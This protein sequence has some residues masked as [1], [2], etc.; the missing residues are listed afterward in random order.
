MGLTVQQFVRNLTETGIMSVDELG[1]LRQALPHENLDFT[2]NGQDAQSLAQELVRQHKLTEY[3]A[4]LLCGGEPGLTL[5][6]YIIMDDLGRGGMGRVFKAQH[7]R[8]KRVVALKVL[9]PTAMQ[10]PESV[11]RFQREVEAAAKLNHPNIVAAYD[12]DEEQG[13]H[14][15]VMEYV[16]GTSLG[17][18]VAGD[19]LDV[20]C[21]INYILQAAYALRY[22]HQQGVVHRDIKPTNLLL[23]AS[24]VVKVLDMGLARVDNRPGVLPEEPGQKLTQAGQIMGTIDFMSPEQ[25]EDTRQ[26]DARSDIYSLGCTMYSLLTGEVPYDGDT[27]MRKLLAHRNNPIPS[28]IAKRTDVPKELEAIFHRMVAKRPADR[29]QTM[30]EVIEA[31]ETCASSPTEG[32]ASGMLKHAFGSGSYPIVRRA[33]AETSALGADPTLASRPAAPRVAVPEEELILKEDADRLKAEQAARRPPPSNDLIKLACYCGHRFAVRSDHAGKKVKCPSCKETML[34]HRAEEKAPVPP[35]SAAPISVQCGQC[36]KRLTVS[37]KLAGK[38]VKCSQCS[39][40]IKIVAA[41][42]AERDEPASSAKRAKAT[43][44]QKI[45]ARC[46]CGKQLTASVNLAGKT[47]KCPSCSAPIKVPRSL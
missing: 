3:Q 45:S 30:S 16:E 24:G 6:S 10:S 36:G 25:A 7:R 37:A 17:D 33:D 2:L 15:L 1:E 31:L 26:A 20:P 47:V 32:P 46:K 14:Y 42:S 8:M 34:V 27:V 28:L 41:V 9:S 19:P 12:A 39:S 5:G 18:R 29:Y 40:P 44:S 38:T 13:V 4:R 21:T 23:D 11:Q 35:T 22:A 43:N